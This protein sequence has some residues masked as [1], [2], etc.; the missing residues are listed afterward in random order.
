MVTDRTQCETVGNPRSDTRGSI[1]IE[2]VLWI[3]LLFSELIDLIWRLTVRHVLTRN[4]PGVKLPKEC[5]FTSDG[6]FFIYIECP[7]LNKH[8]L[9]AIKDGNVTDIR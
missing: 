6:T 2:I 1:A 8:G 9:I 7:S 4:T 3:G 5:S